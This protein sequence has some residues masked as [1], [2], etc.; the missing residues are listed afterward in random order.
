MCP[1]SPKLDDEQG[2][3]VHTRVRV[4]AAYPVPNP[5]SPQSGKQLRRITPN[6][7]TLFNLLLPA[8]CC[9][10]DS[11]PSGLPAQSSFPYQGGPAAVDVPGGEVRTTTR[12]PPT[13]LFGDPAQ[14]NW[15]RRAKGCPTS[16]PTVKSPSPAMIS[17]Q[18]P[19]RHIFLDPPW[20]GTA[21]CPTGCKMGHEILL[22][23]R[24][25]SFGH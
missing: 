17:L 18:L 23:L 7:A 5:L 16:P 19:P 22:A 14:L 2:A 12:L 24:G 11:E 8:E 20:P 13:L 1:R 21:D 6:K 3:C 10:P 25:S 4:C 9:S 15:G